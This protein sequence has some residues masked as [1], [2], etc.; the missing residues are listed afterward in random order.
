M[1][2]LK[3]VAILRNYIGLAVTLGIG[4]GAPLGGILTDT[5]GWR[6]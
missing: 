2:P 3:E 1:M 6:W 5:I 4:S